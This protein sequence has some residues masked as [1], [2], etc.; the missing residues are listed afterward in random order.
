MTPWAPAPL[1]RSVVVGPGVPPP[2]PWEDADRFVVDEAV[3]ARPTEV[4]EAL[5]RRWAARRP[6]VVDLR[7]PAAALRGA[8]DPVGAGG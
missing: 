6:Y 7:V 2:G 4:V 1:G 8:T 3:L 5:H